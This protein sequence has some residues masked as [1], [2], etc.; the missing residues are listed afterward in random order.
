M[1]A[2]LVQLVGLERTEV[3]R[4]R[5][6]PAPILVAAG[7]FQLAVVLTAHLGSALGVPL[8]VWRPTVVVPLSVVGTTAL[9]ACLL[10]PG[11]RLRDTIA[12][13]RR[14]AQ[15]VP[16]VLASFIMAATVSALAVMAAELFW[17]PRPE[18]TA[19]IAERPASLDVLALAYELIGAPWAEELLF[20]LLVLGALLATRLTPAVAIPLSATLFASSHLFLV[21]DVGPIA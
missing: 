8:G 14:P 17:H 13:P 3:P 1:G 6:G 5:Y 19:F 12:W 15:I 16:L 2:R 7:L 10:P 20:R 21:P 18:T 9:A 4:L 11:C